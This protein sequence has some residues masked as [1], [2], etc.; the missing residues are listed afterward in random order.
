MIT[1]PRVHSES[2]QGDIIWRNTCRRRT[3]TI[4]TC[5]LQQR[6]Q[7]KMGAS[8]LSEDWWYALV[9]FKGILKQGRELGEQLWKRMSPVGCQQ[10]GIESTGVEVNTFICSWFIC[11]LVVYLCGWLGG[12]QGSRL[13][14]GSPGVSPWTMVPRDGT[15]P[16]TVRPS[17]KYFTTCLFPT[18]WYDPPPSKRREVGHPGLYESN[19]LSFNKQIFP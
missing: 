10:D 13:V 15:P 11:C 2:V 14:W 1:K 3:G 12:N 16:P 5:G 6:L 8:R 17:S 4:F 7:V 19:V 18:S 9:G